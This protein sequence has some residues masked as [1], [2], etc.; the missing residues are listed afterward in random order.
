VFIVWC[1]ELLSPK[2][3]YSESAAQVDDA[4]SAG[5]ADSEEPLSASKRRR[6]TTFSEK[7]AHFRVEVLAFYQG[8]HHEDWADKFHEKALDG[9]C[10]RFATERTRLLEKAL[11]SESQSLDACQLPAKALHTFSAH[12]KRGY[13]KKQEDSLLPGLLVPMKDLIYHVEKLSIQTSTSFKLLGIKITFWSLV[14]SGSVAAGFET[15]STE[16]VTAIYCAGSL[17]NSR[18]DLQA[19]QFVL[20]LCEKALIVQVKQLSADEGLGM[21]NRTTSD[22]VSY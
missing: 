14:N 20:P 8:L 17:T 12:Y 13:G 3:P 11:V 18:N 22:N 5:G 6:L 4:R 21:A 1:G 15:L 7:I 19:V 16:G 9:L 2:V 10:R